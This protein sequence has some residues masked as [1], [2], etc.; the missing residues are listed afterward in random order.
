MISLVS[1]KGRI[2]AGKFM[3]GAYPF[4]DVEP[5]WVR[6]PEEMGSKAKFW[7]RE[8]EANGSNWLFKHPQRSTGEHWA[9][10]LAEQV[11]G[12]LGV[13][14]ARVELARFRGQQGTAT[15]SF[16]AGGGILLHGNQLL[17][18]ILDAY[19][20]DKRFGQ[21][22]HT[23]MRILQTIDAV[24]SPSEDAEHAKRQIA[25]YLV[26]DALIGNTDRHHENWGLLFRPGAQ[27]AV[28]PSFDHASSLG[29]ELRDER[30]VRLLKE[31]RI[32]WYAERGRGAVYWSEGSRRGP[33]PLQ[34]VRCAARA[35]ADVF[36]SALARL[37][38]VDDATLR[39]LLGAYIEGLTSSYPLPWG[40]T[41]VLFRKN[42]HA[43]AATRSAQ[44]NHPLI[45]DG[46][47]RPRGTSPDRL[48]GVVRPSGDRQAPAGSSGTR[49]WTSR[50][51][52]MTSR[53]CA[54]RDRRR[55]RSSRSA[56]RSRNSAG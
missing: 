3:V 42:T 36:R 22:G 14:Y 11:A 8:P 20:P 56:R 7:Y 51:S 48:P 41:V 18:A 31:E 29:R 32:G 53:G 28:A 30:R 25:D 2:P 35:H 33:S 10:K 50:S 13:S 54:A 38:Q 27:V 34:L 39:E 55:R 5:E 24:I 19:D 6:Q 46:N 40:C 23:L 15:E 4:L 47:A 26:I 37:D 17:D 49:C 43:T 52:C 9:E 1:A 45:G 44:L 12:A 21:S 16:T